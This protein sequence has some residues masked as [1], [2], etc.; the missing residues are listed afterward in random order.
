VT[1]DAPILNSTTEYT[2]PSEEQAEPISDYAETVY[3]RLTMAGI[4]LAPGVFAF[5][6]GGLSY[7][8]FRL[9]TPNPTHLG[10]LACNA[11]YATF[12]RRAH[13]ESGSALSEQ[14][15]ERVASERG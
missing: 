7:L 1:P 2:A 3:V 5:L 6:G 4:W 15:M 8:T 12:N 10:A 14:N 9:V 11:P 13:D